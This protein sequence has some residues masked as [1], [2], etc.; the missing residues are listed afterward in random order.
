MN[1]ERIEMEIEKFT[2]E[3]AESPKPKRETRKNVVNDNTYPFKQD[4]KCI[5]F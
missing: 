4:I 5:I 2:K 3:E 1:P